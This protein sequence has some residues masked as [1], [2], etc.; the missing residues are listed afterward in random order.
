MSTD[1]LQ[2]LSDTI[3]GILNEPP[4]PATYFDPEPH[5]EETAS[6]RV[7]GTSDG[8]APG[9]DVLKGSFGKLSS[10]EA[11][12]SQNRPSEARIVS[13]EIESP[14]RAS[15]HYNTAV[16]GQ[17]SKLEPASLRSGR[18]TLGVN[19]VRSPVT[20]NRPS[21]PRW[22]MFVLAGIVL[23]AGFGVAV[24]VWLGASRDGAKANS[25]N[26]SPTAAASAS[27]PP[28]LAPLLQSMSR[29]LVSLR[30][31]IEQL[32]RGRE[33][34]IRDSASF[35][36]QFKASQDQLGRAVARLS[37]QVKAGQ[38]AAERDNAN[39]SEQIRAVREQLI[40]LEQNAAPKKLPPVPRAATPAAPKPAPA[41]SSPPAAAQ[42]A[43]A[44]PKP[45]P[46]AVA[47]A[48]TS[49]R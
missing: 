35:G 10:R 4:S 20:H 19:P 1:R 8:A 26:S 48:S 28:D 22:G 46:S 23:A 37:D 42:P 32:K 5:D 31:E 44:K 16:A 21:L 2:T 38:E 30:G 33:Q 34:M 12:I 3:A 45:A 40:R 17:P 24:I 18:Q 47:P 43:A 11:G 6:E 39:A 15:E 7:A 14:G 13:H 25:Q 49:V 9:T 27:L 41:T 29:D 36:E